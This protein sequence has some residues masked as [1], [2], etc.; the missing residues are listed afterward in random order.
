MINYHKNLFS[1]YYARSS[2]LFGLWSH[3]GSVNDSS[4]HRQKMNWLWYFYKITKVRNG[5]G[6]T[7]V[8]DHTELGYELHQTALLA[9]QENHERK[10][11]KGYIKQRPHGGVCVLLA[12]LVK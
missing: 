3:L 6:K 7:Q 8:L 5:H 1:I 2:V 9:L 10:Q 11:Q 4:P 12:V